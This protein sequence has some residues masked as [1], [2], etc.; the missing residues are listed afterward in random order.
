[1][2]KGKVIGQLPRALGDMPAVAA[3]GASYV[4]GGALGE[5]CSDTIYRVETS[6][7][8]SPVARMPVAMRAHQA[9]VIQDIIYVFGGFTNQTRADVFRLDLY[10]WH[11]TPLASMPRPAAWFTVSTIDKKVYVV[12]GFAGPD[13]YWNSIAVFDV[14]LNRWKSFDHSFDHP[15]FPRKRLGSNAAISNKGRI[16]SFGGADT[17]DTTRMR[18]NALSS[19]AEFEPST[20]SWRPLLIDIVPR[21]GLVAVRNER[22]AYLIGGMTEIPEGPSG[23]VERVDMETGQKELFASLATPRVAPGVTIIGDTLFVIGGVVNP[24]FEMTADIEAIDLS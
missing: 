16:I 6:G 7:A 9:V 2:K 23:L 12:G 11:V 17:F 20:A 19:A 21:E 18:A 14:R 24:P 4:L 10:D 1:M 22:F 15:L 5:E 13:D 3:R 8:V